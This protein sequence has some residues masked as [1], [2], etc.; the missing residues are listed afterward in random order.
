MPKKS[1]KEL[2]EEGEKDKSVY[3]EEGREQLVEEDE[4]EPFEE[5]FMEGAE[6]RGKKSCCAEC[7]KALNSD[8]GQL[9][10]RE[11][12]GETLW[13]CSDKHAHNYAKKHP[14]KEEPEEEED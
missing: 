7:G 4:I 6:G 13:F 9:F 8:K 2:I 1:T 11:F 14:E 3:G 10:E 5:G 12:N